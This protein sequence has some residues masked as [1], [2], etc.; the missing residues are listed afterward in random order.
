MPLIVLTV[1]FCCF[2]TE[3]RSQ[4]VTNVNFNN[5]MVAGNPANGNWSVQAGGTEVFQSI[6]GEET[7]FISP[8]DLINVEISGEFRTTDSD[9]DWM[10]FVFGFNDPLGTNYN[11]FDLLLFDWKQENQGCAPRGM[12]LAKVTGTLSAAQI[13]NGFSCHINSPEFTIL[14]SDFQGPGWIRNQWHQ[15]RLIYTFSRIIIYID[16]VLRF[17]VSGC[18]KPGRFGFYNRSQR[19]CTYR[20]FNYYLDID[21]AVTSNIFCP[22]VPV[23]FMFIDHACVANFDFNQIQSMLWQFGDGNQF[24][25]NNPTFANVNPSH[26]YAQP[27][28]YQ[29]TLTLTDAL[30]CSDSETKTVII[31]QPP[32]A[33]FTISHSCHNVPTTI[34]NTSAGGS[35][36][37][38]T[39]AMW[40]MGDGSV[41]N[42]INPGTYTYNAAGLYTVS[43]HVTDANGCTASTS[44]LVTIIDDLHPLLAATDAHCPSLNDGA[45]SVLN[46]TDG[47]APYTYNWNNG[48]N[49]QTIQGL[50]PGSYFVTVTDSRGCTGT[51]SAQIGISNTTSLSYTFIV[52]DYN[53][54]NISCHGANDAT[55]TIQMINGTPPYDYTW[56]HGHSG[57]TALHL[58]AGSYTVSVI[59]AHSCSA[60]ATLTITQPPILM[61]HITISS[62]YHGQ[63]I[64]CHGA[65]DGTVTASATGGVSPYSYSWSTGNNTSDITNLNAGTYSVTV[66]DSNGC[67]GEQSITLSEPPPLSVSLIVSDYNGYAV[68]CFN[69]RDGF[70]QAQVTGGTPDYLYLW[71]TGH[72]QPVATQLASGHYAVT[73][74]DANNCRAIAQIDLMEPSAL[75]VSLSASPPTCHGY[76]NGYVIADARGGIMPYTYLW[77]NGATTPLNNNLTAG[78]YSLTVMD[79]NNCTWQTSYTL[80]QPDPVIVTIWSEHDTIPFYGAST[81]LISSY[82]ANGNSIRSFR[83]EPTTTLSNPYSQNT[84]ARPIQTTNYTLTVTDED[85]C[86]G[87]AHITIHVSPDKALYIPN[88]FSPNGDGINDVFQI[89]TH[90]DGI[91]QF[92]L[93]IF[94]RWGRLVF[95]SFDLAAT[96]NGNF[97]GRE[98]NPGNYVYT[99]HIIYTDGDS[100]KKQGTITLLR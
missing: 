40:D 35:N 82:S 96:W 63:A 54:F 99:L 49:N 83:W 4:C 50:T 7:F 29:V 25:N 76:A 43:L 28:T 16:N 39:A 70:A 90:A 41:L 87:T 80:E 91:R 20:N 1:A 97:N 10:G 71:N 53:G 65:N 19:N 100:F 42:H 13:T 94:D 9:D 26:S 56:N 32:L 2:I 62:N 23:Q 21:F 33:A 93:R 36:T 27:G 22:H 31:H 74:Y 6:N 84:Q 18:F 60:T 47:I 15:F 86:V 34:V 14:A 48:Q 95:E 55:A 52:S 30:G 89:Y 66:T 11:T 58:T 68:S 69:G 64:S 45:I 77:N 92:T 8:F 72:S 17:D 12:C 81:Q 75:D 5:W 78:N 67:I 57:P 24:I 59:D 85:R 3:A 79:A 38:I 98:L 61:P 88:A 37:P 73:I 46:V 51:G 44:Q